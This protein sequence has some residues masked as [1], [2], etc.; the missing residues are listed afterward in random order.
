[1]QIQIAYGMPMHP[2]PY[3]YPSSKMHSTAPLNAKSSSSP[4][5]YSARR[6]ATARYDNEQRNQSSDR[7][8]PVSS[9]DE[10]EESLNVEI[11]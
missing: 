5:N 3:F 11:D 1:M 7:R 9:D 4:L 2:F 6:D 8:T 10:R